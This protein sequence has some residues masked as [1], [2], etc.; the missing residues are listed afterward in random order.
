VAILNFAFTP[1]RLDEIVGVAFPEN[2]ASWRVL[3]KAGMRYV[4]TVRYHGIDGLKEYVADRR[5]RAP[6]TAKRH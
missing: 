1:A 2:V 5:T 3:E 4:G 6:P